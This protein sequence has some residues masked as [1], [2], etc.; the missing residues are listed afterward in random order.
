MLTL[1][2]RCR[3]DHPPSLI[4]LYYHLLGQTN[5]LYNCPVVH[6]CNHNGTT[7]RNFPF[8]TLQPDAVFDILEDLGY[9]TLCEDLS[10]YFDGK[11]PLLL[12]QEMQDVDTLPPYCVFRLSHHISGT[13]FDA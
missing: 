2:H 13:M 5:I 9:S 4:P 8:L 1:K 12:V 10:L 11:D 3:L 7:H 6:P